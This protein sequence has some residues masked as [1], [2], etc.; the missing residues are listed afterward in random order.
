MPRNLTSL[1]AQGVALL[2]LGVGTCVAA[3]FLREPVVL[4]PGLC[5]ALL[6]LA[7]WLVLSRARPRLRLA[8]TPRPAEVEAGTPLDVD[9]VVTQSGAAAPWPLTVTDFVPTSFGRPQSMRLSPPGAGRATGATYQ[10]RPQRRGRFVLDALEFSTSEP[11]GLARHRTRPA[12]RTEVLVTPRVFALETAEGVASGDVAEETSLPHLAFG[13]P[14]DVL[15]REYR[16]RDDVRR[17]HWPSTARTGTL[18]VRREEQEWDPIAWVLLDTRPV[19]AASEAAADDRFEYLVSLAASVGVTLL[20][21]GFEVGL[22]TPDGATFAS[23]S[24]VHGTPS[25]DWLRHLVDARPTVGT[26]ATAVSA[27]TPGPTGH[28]IVAVLGRLT[29]GD[30]MAL[31]TLGS[32]RHR[33]LCLY[34][35]VS[36]PDAAAR[37]DEAQAIDLLTDAHWH[38]APV[39]V[40]SDPAPAWESLS[41]AL[42][43]GRR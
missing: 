43:G 11:L 7:S 33:C 27:V 21:H 39:T 36:T 26:M 17:I 18:M 25:R 3:W 22:S 31:S 32:L 6:P 28:L 20:D 16:P 40:G 14:D 1:T 13:G 35:P 37:A 5:L 12:L 30:A 42:T 23:E 8:R 24:R 41:G 34:V 9:V 29:Q 10:C 4:W 15:V 19:A 2:V 38:L